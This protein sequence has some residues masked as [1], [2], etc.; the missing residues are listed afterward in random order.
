MSRLTEP[1][2]VLEASPLKVAAHNARA[3]GGSVLIT[4]EIG[5]HALLSPED[6]A[7]YLSGRVENA[8][9]LAAGAGAVKGLLQ[10]DF[11]R[12]Q[13]DFAHLADRTVPRH[14]LDWKGPNVHTV[15]V[16]LRCNFKCLYCHASVVGLERTDMDM[17]VATAKSVVDLI[18]QSPSP[19]LMIEFQGGEPLL[20]WEALSAAA[21]YARAK[22]KETGKELRLA[23]VSNF[24]RMSREKAEF[25]LAHEV[26]IC[27]SLD[28]PAWLHNANRVYSGGDSHADTVRWLKFFSDRHDGQKGGAR[29]FKPG[30]LLTVTRKSLSAPEE[31][32]DEYVK[33][34]L[35]EIFIR[36][37][38]PLGFAAKVWGEIGYDA[39]EFGVFYR[40]ALD[41]MLRLNARGVKIKE[42]MASIMLEKIVNFTEPGYLDARCPCGAGIGQLAYNF[43]GDIYTCD[44]GRMAAWAGDDLFRVGNVFKDQYKKVMGSGAVKACLAASN[45]E[46]Q[47]VC[48][49]CAY[50]P[51]CGVC[52]VYNYEVQGSLAGDMPTNQRCALQKEIF[53][54][55]FAALN[56]KD[57]GRPLR[58]W[59]AGAA[60]VN[61]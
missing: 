60:G 1:A 39:A 31:I 55:V 15:V 12:D 13:L 18:F 6:Y 23:L 48:S 52:P 38:Q 58:A 42:K 2:G 45:L 21:R 14:L 8:D 56:R 4:N 30:A 33:R 34:G 16:T 20:N 35:E 7:R 40:K 28:G 10:K 59:V 43:N 19:N 46:T 27:G 54:A 24:T 5:E 37:L 17:T 11:V 57:H 41:Y 25:L 61:S 44:E 26:S 53:G 22:V 9:P 29:I 36:P 3:V 49:R 51:Y 50:R 32:V 47:P